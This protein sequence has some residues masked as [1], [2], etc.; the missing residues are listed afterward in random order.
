MK[1]GGWRLAWRLARRDLHRSVLG[2][3]LL[4]VC[5]F[6]GTATLAGDRQ[7]DR[8]DHRRS[9][10]RAARRSSAATSRCR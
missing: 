4:F 1:G 2:L 7:P 10:R 3:R 8:F 9:W 5:L 6:L